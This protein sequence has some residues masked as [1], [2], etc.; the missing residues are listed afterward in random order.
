MLKGTLDS[1]AIEEITGDTDLERFQS[2]IPLSDIDRDSFR[3]WGIDDRQKAT[4]IAQG[5]VLLFYL[6]DRQYEF[7]S[8]VL[9]G[10][11]QLPAAFESSL[12]E[13][14]KS[15]ENVDYCVLTSKPVSVTIPSRAIAEYAG[16]DV[17]YVLSLTRF[18]ERGLNAIFQDHNNVSTFFDRHSLV[19]HGDEGLRYIQNIQEFEFTQIFEAERELEIDHATYEFL[20]R[21]EF[22][23]T[24]SARDRPDLPTLFPDVDQS[25]EWIPSEDEDVPVKRLVPDWYRKLIQRLT[26]IG[27]ATLYGPSTCISSRAIDRFFDWWINFAGR[28]KSPNIANGSGQRRIEEID[29]E[30]V[31]T[32]SLIE[33][34]VPSGDEP[35]IIDGQFKRTCLLADAAAHEA[36]YDSE[37]VDEYVVVLRAESDVDLSSLL[38]EVFEL[39]DPEQRA[40]SRYTGSFGPE[41]RL[42][43]S[44]D[45]LRIPPNLYILLVVDAAQGGIS[46]RTTSYL[47]T[48]EASPDLDRYLSEI[49]WTSISDLDSYKRALQALARLN[50]QIRSSDELG[51]AYQYDGTLLDRALST[52][53]E[54]RQ[55]V[56]N[57][58]W[59]EQIIPPLRQEITDEST[60]TELFSDIEVPISDYRSPGDTAIETII[61]EFATN[62]SG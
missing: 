56:I 50:T 26:Q 38:G 1:D 22:S 12:Q 10:S 53:P 58:V 27:Q 14:G 11:D 13:M 43:N 18:P 31:D 41:K 62:W 29:L 3:L 28:S 46:S 47:P 5:D 48:I 35:H 4:Q 54:S 20:S 2:G 51:P 42:T 40:K 61:Q 39:L 34:I 8:V 21:S 7:V 57:N 15:R 6:G 59:R 55:R 23:G 9:E 37:P 49:D 17:Q 25:A 60:L 16:F 33:R 19:E 30:S 52:P 45:Q 24:L 32:E 36:Y 44:G